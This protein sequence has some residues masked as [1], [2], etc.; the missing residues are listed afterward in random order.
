LIVWLEQFDDR[1]YGDKSKA[2]KAAL[3]QGIDKACE[4]TPAQV[5]FDADGLKE[6][7]A[8]A[9]ADM[10]PDLT[11][12]R[13]IVEVGVLSALS[14]AGGQIGAASSSATEEDDETEAFLDALA[15]EL[16]ITNDDLEEVNDG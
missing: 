7:I 6:A 5:D 8:T 15:G 3:L 4:Q 2:I 13:Q 14:Q 9:L 16:V 12:I 1:P 10:I 11:E